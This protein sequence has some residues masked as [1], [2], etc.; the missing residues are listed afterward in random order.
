[1]RMMLRR[2]TRTTLFMVTFSNMSYNL[3]LPFTPETMVCFFSTA[4]EV[5]L[6]CMNFRHNLITHT[7]SLVKDKGVMFKWTHT[8]L[9]RYWTESTI[10]KCQSRSHQ[11]WRTEGI[12]ES[13]SIDSLITLEQPLETSWKWD[14]VISPQTTVKCSPS[15]R[16][17]L[18]CVCI[19]P[20]L[21]RR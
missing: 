17:L 4:F 6:C 13:N 19:N 16:L 9:Q 2:V 20:V 21:D 15:F 11:A 7:Q 12:R 3:F 8:L 1:M 5:I 18:Q 10:C 14:K